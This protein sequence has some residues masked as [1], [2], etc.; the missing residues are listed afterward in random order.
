VGIILKKGLQNTIITYIG[1]TLGFVNIIVLQPLFLKPED[2]GLLRII[3][4]L[5]S[6]VALVAPLG[7]SNITIK[8]FS[9][10]RN[11]EKRHHGFL[12]FALLYTLIGYFIIA[13]LVYILKDWINAK[14]SVNSPLF[15]DYFYFIFP[16]SF[17]MSVSSVLNNYCNVIYKPL[18]PSF[19]NEIFVRIAYFIIILLYFL[20]TIDFQFLVVL[21][22]FIYLFQLLGLL[23]FVL[24][25]EKTHLM[26]DREE[27][28]KKKIIEMAKY[29]LPFTLA[30]I[31]A[32][33][34][35]QIDSIMLGWYA[36]LSIVGIY[37][38][39]MFIP[40]II[41]A[42]IPAIDKTASTKVSDAWA[43]GDDEAIKNIYFRS[44][45]YLL[46]LGGI[47]FLGIVL[48]I[49]SLYA[50]LPSD[51][52]LGINVVYVIS[53]GSLFNM[54]SGLNN[55]IIFGS[56]HYKMGLLFLFT[57]FAFTVIGN[58]I[59]IPLW[60]MIGA[61][62]SAAFGSLAYNFL[63]YLYIWKK[64]KLQPFNLNTLKAIAIISFTFFIGYL[65]PDIIHPAF[66]IIY[67]SIIIT[68]IYGLLVYYLKL[69]PEINQL[70]YSRLS[71]LLK[72]KSR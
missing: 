21:Y 23:F 9:Y 62:V 26:Y 59:L 58:L 70:I 13:I 11:V 45:E 7:I 53:L 24:K 39:A 16:M 63:K 68:L 30:A 46:L 38:L 49:H 8:Y 48:N 61:A 22:V 57:M 17:F 42:P 36:P 41:E 47:L 51:F 10:Y 72:K 55:Q 44:T 14:Y 31:S 52:S 35:K 50:M 27:I 20:K 25:T 43:K 6:L 2:I 19:L 60:G 29:G 1:I 15:I 34:V 5:S 54:M 37:T 28:S 67:R 3:F 69:V 71:L 65:L 4:A 56:T 18:L 32:V 66:S 33:G 64:F 40:T 12:G